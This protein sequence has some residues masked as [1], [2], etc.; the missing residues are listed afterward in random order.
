VRFAS[1]FAL[2]LGVLPI[3]L[4][5]ERIRVRRRRRRDAVRFSNVALIR[6]AVPPVSMV[7]RLLPGLLFVLSAGSLIAASARP[8]VTTTVPLARTTILLAMDVSRSMCAD[9]VAPN[10]L[11]ASQSAARYF[12]T[13]QPRGTRL[14]LI[15]FSGSAHLVLAPTT[16][17]SALVNA[18]DAM[19]T[20]NGTA[21][22]AA[23]LTGID[24][25]AEF[26]GD[27]D[28]SEAIDPS[29]PTPVVAP[30]RRGYV[31]GVVVLLTDG[32]NTQ[33]VL[34]FLAARQAAVRG[35]RIYTIG[36][37]TD[38]ATTLVCSAKQLGAD[39]LGDAVL[40]VKGADPGGAGQSLVI[41]EGELQ[42][43]AHDTGG[44]YF[45]AR[46]ERRLR[47]VF[48]RLPKTFV[49]ERRRTEISA[50]FAGLGAL[51]VLAAAGLSLRWRAAGFGCH[52]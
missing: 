19:S 26:N 21:I 22:G 14:G 23:V 40:G 51:L 37:G 42:A 10:R 9:D 7:R 11:A 4:L 27:V 33:G 3:L 15:E 50:L 46:D 25:L 28:P 18:I 29:R 34:P 16:D 31:S 35:V 30:G 45:R 49:L 5:V 6:V 20:S 39:A 24:A 36:F 17:R 47:S 1:P 12:V 43:L 13:H 44:A 38:H 2:W 32:A 52:R 48:A 8:S 41:D